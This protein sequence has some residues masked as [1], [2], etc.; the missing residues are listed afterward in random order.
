M[1]I[2]QS[3]PTNQSLIKPLH[4]GF[5]PSIKPIFRFLLQFSNC[6]SLAVAAFIP[7]Q[8]NSDGDIEER[9]QCGPD[10]T[11]VREID[12]HQRPAVSSNHP[13][14][15]LLP[16]RGGRYGNPGSRVNVTLE[17]R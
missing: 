8:I 10:H 15:A 14:R 16:A 3:T 12:K 5:I 17:Q 11:L 2:D 9:R 1:P 7:I 4:S 13:I 6:F